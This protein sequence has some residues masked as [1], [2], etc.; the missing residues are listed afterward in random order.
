MRIKELT[1][2]PGVSG[3]EDAVREYIVG[4]ARACA[5]DVRVD[6]LGNVIAIKRG[7]AQMRKNIMVCAHMDEVGFMITGIDDDGLLRFAPV[8]GID[9]RILPSMRVRIGKQGIPGVIGSVAV[10]LLTAADRAKPLPLK[11]MYF[12]IGVSTRAQ[13][14]ALVQLGDWAVFDSK[15]V[16]MG[17][18]L[19][20]A[21]ALDDRVGCALLLDALQ[22]R[23]EATLTAV[24]S[25]QEEV[26]CRGAQT[27][28][29]AVNP[30]AAVVLEGTTCADMHGVPDHQKVTRIGQGAVLS[31]MDRSAIMD[32]KMRRFLCGVANDEGVKWQDR[33]GTWG[34]TD[35]GAIQLAL[36]GRAVVNI[37]VPCRYIHSPVSV[38]SYDDYQNAQVLLRAFLTRVNRY[39]NEEEGVQ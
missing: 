2:L 35:A 17:D 39:M 5:D 3:R 26:G 15:P 22:E 20:K 31:M 38:M 9:P 27:A 36:A 21:K 12:D 1:S 14:Q 8:G 18:N 10:H 29:Y 4:Q 37:S 13:A 23:Y 19:L 11:D 34:G 33:Q 30:D 16:E 24:F 28:A 32:V 25:V 6:A 7:T